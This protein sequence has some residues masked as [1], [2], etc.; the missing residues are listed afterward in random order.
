[1]T[2]TKINKSF[3]TTLTTLNY[4]NLLLFPEIGKSQ[5]IRLLRAQ[6]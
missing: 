1:M 2:L 3:L 6:A 5:G 4:L